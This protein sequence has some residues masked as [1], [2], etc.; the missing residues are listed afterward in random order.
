MLDSDIK[1][2]IDKIREILVGRVPSPQSQVDHITN[3]LI[4]KFMHDMDE[5]AVSLGGERSFFTGDYEKYAWSNYFDP[6]LGG[7]ER[8]Q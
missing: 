6:K 3:A 1:K 8:V 5:E 7:E 4:Y 2:R